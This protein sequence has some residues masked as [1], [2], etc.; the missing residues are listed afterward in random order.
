MSN[1]LQK[2]FVPSNMRSGGINV[3]GKVDFSHDL[4]KAEAVSIWR[5]GIYV[6]MEED[7][8]WSYRPGKPG[9]ASLLGH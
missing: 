6:R 5:K 3:S 8:C 2:S 7:I 9:N 1:C 4:G